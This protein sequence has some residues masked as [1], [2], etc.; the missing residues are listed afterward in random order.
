MVEVLMVEVRCSW[1]RWGAH[2]GGE[3]LMVEVRC[4]WWR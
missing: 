3:V 2:G 1:W 4:S